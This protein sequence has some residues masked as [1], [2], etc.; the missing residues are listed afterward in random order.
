MKATLHQL[1]IFRVVAEEGSISRAARRLHLTPPT[2][3]VQLRQLAE[4]LDVTLYEIVGR[5]LT[6]TGAGED[7]LEAAQ[8]INAETQRLDQRLAARG[9]VER[10]RLRISAVSTAEYL[11]PALLG[12]FQGRH[13]GIETSLR[14][15]PRDDIVQRIDAGLDDDYLMTRPP[16]DQDIEIERIG[17]NPLVMIA[18]P[19]HPWT[20]R[21]R[22][23]FGSVDKARFVVREEGSGTRLWTE[24]WLRRFGAELHPS[25]ELGSNEAIK[26]AVRGGHGLAVISLHAVRLE[27]EAGLLTILRVPHF[28]APVFWHLIQ[29]RNTPVSPAAAVFR[30]HLLEQMPEHDAWA[31][32]VIQDHGLRWPSEAGD[33]LAAWPNQT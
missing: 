13:P 26:Q 23:D 1:R 9:G 8:N 28:P 24:E 15:A 7:V 2:L 11:L 14:I 25:M 29:R 16:A 6:L 30:E 21:R 22:I 32:S 12:R 31:R 5:K 18:T 20:K 33:K 17:V 10:G 27:L 4:N 19:D 3:S